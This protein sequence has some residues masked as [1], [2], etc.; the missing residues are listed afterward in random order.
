MFRVTPLPGIDDDEISLV[1]QHIIDGLSFVLSSSDDDT[2]ASGLPH[3]MHASTFSALAFV[4]SSKRDTRFTLALP[5]WQRA[6]AWG[7]HII[8]GDSNYHGEARACCHRSDSITHL[9]STLPSYAIARHPITG[10]TYF[11]L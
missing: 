5:P 9:L 4:L 7:R 3:W 11:S 6:L 8:T 10:V 2:A 1:V